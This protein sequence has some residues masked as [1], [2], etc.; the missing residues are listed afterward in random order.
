MSLAWDHIPFEVEP[1]SAPAVVECLS[2]F[3]EVYCNG[4]ALV[5]SFKYPQNAAFERDLHNHTQNRDHIFRALLSNPFVIAALPELQ[6]KLP[7]KPAPRFSMLSA[8]A[9]EGE[10]T[11]LLLHGGAYQAFDGTVNQARNLTRGMMESLVG[12]KMQTVC[13]A[14]YSTTPWTPW[15]F[16][17]AWDATFVLYQQKTRRFVVICLTDTD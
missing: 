17:I 5:R 9:I 1:I 15:F 4:G 12:P 3:G 13:L 11:N 6:I 8:F 10:L 2:A 7:L 16:R 14:G